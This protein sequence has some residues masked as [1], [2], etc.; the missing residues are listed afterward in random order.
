MVAFAG[1]AGC[2]SGPH[3]G[4]LPSGSPGATSG[5]GGAKTNGAG[6]GAAPS[7]T[8]TGAAATGLSASPTGLIAFKI[9]VPG[10]VPFESQVFTDPLIS[11]LDLLIQWKNLEPAFGNFDWTALDCLFSQ[12]DEH[13]KFVVLTLVPGF[14][15]PSWVLGLNGVLSQS[16]MFSYNGDAPARPLPLPWNK[17]YLDSWF[18]FLKSV[19]ARYGTNPEFRMIQVAGPTSVSSEMSLPDRTSGDTA[20]PPSTGGSDIVEW[21]N[22]GYTPAKYVAAWSDTFSEYHQLFPDQYLALSL[23][24]G[25]PIGDNGTSDPRQG[26][27][28][29]LDII[30]SGR[31]F[32]KSFVLQENG[33]KGVANPRPDPEYNFVKAGCG[34]GVTGLQDAKSATTDPVGEGPLNLALA[35]GVAAD[36][37]FLEVYEADVLN[38]GMHDLLATTSAA[39]PANRG[40]A[41]LTLSAN[42]QTARAGTPATIT[43]VTDL[44][45][46]RNED[47]NV[48]SAER[49]LKTC[50]QATCAVLASPGPGVTTYTADV[51]EPGTPPD[52]NQAIVSATTTVSRQ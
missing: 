44:D 28:T 8:P 27:A 52:T 22:L 20:L 7:C 16:F 41:P 30:A 3:P 35:H 10:Q 25:L 47:I 48:Y 12:A 51:A 49:L 5:G 45:L 37:S 33:V 26:A 9:Y 29:P 34:S 19:S 6:G 32:G 1:L 38:P 18:T 11:G 31:R 43:A 23:F 36:V 21:M 50:A 42:P 2:S 4:A 24:P 40:C 39:L 46:A 17:P 13:K 15:S 14:D